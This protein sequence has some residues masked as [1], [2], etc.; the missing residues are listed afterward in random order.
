MKMHSQTPI[1]TLLSGEVTILWDA[2]IYQLPTSLEEG[3]E[4]AVKRIFLPI[5][6]RKYWKI[7]SNGQL[8]QVVVYDPICGSSAC[9]A[10]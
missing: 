6:A 3:Q 9:I 7:G 1:I 8:V 5:V 4:P 10:P 2:G